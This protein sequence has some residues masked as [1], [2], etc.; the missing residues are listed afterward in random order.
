MVTITQQKSSSI[1]WLSLESGS[2]VFKCCLVNLYFDKV[3]VELLIRSWYK[4]GRM[5][6]RSFWLQFSKQFKNENVTWLL[7]KAKTSSSLINNSLPLYNLHA[8]TS[9]LLLYV[10]SRT[11]LII[12]KASR[13]D[14]AVLPSFANL[15][16]Y[17]AI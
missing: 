17:D 6:S 2:W 15:R 4:F 8:S 1:F 11:F 3:S 16:C 7:K 14:A 5:S 9:K 13:S 12:D 10:S